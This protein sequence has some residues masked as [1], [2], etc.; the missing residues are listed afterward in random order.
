LDGSSLKNSKHSKVHH[1][2]CKQSNK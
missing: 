2:L 1:F